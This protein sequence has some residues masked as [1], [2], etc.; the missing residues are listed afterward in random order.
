MARKAKEATVILIGRG[1]DVGIDLEGLP[2]LLQRRFTARMNLNFV[3]PETLE[4]AQQQLSSDSL[5][6]KLR[7]GPVL[8]VIH[9]GS[10]YEGDD[11]YSR[12][13]PA[14]KLGV[15]L[16]GRRGQI[17]GGER[18]GIAEV[19]SFRLDGLGRRNMHFGDTQTVRYGKSFES[20]IVRAARNT[21]GVSTRRVRRTSPQG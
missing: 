9:R 18:I 17:E 3:T 4:A 11:N 8:V 5:A 10:F 7:R 15:G 20:D 12:L 14:E 2:Q 6:L 19:A 16:Q 21:F 13:T 1:G